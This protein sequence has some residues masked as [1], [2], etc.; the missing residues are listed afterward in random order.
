M[1]VNIEK[2]EEIV[3]LSLVANSKKNVCAQKK[4]L[5]QVIEEVQEKR[6]R[7]KEFQLT[8]NI[9]SKQYYRKKQSLEQ[10][11]HQLN[12]R[13]QSLDEG[14]AKIESQKKELEIRQVHIEQDLQSMRVTAEKSREKKMRCERQ[15][16]SVISVPILS[17][18]SKKKYIKARDEYS[19][20][21][22][23][24]S[25][26]RQAL[27]KCRGHLKLIS[28]TVTAQHSEQDQLCNQRRGSVDTIM[29]ST[30][31]LEY[32]TQGRDFWVGFDIYQAKVVL[33][34]AIYLVETEGSPANKKKLAEKELDINQVWQ[35]TFKL[36]CF[37][38]G[39][40]EVYG[41]TRWSMTS[42]EINF[43]CDM[44]QTSQM[45]WP[46]VV[47]ESELACELCYSTIPQQETRKHSITII[48]PSLKSLKE[49][50]I[51]LAYSP[52]QNKMK[53]VLSTLF[54]YRVD[55]L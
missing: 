33:E 9:I 8:V 29:S 55:P 20:A 3:D 32:L 37:E 54:H 7:I 47:K 26:I 16:S 51:D 23:Q 52:H 40:R 34:S 41:D 21:E 28:K 13:G 24:V 11:I 22:Q 5:H 15:Y 39:D 42:L 43:D 10:L 17:A 45:G 44:C 50:K 27:D 35:K 1:T 12:H 30:Q 36:A 19:E 49:S 6:K 14:L 25:E 4:L 2:A 31:Q 18:Q 46:K 48:E 38:Y 53:K